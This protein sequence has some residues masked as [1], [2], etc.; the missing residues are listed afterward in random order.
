MTPSTDPQ[1]LL[2]ADW[3]GGQC[4]YS[5]I[6]QLARFLAGE[7][8]VQILRAPDTRLRRMIGKAYSLL[9]RWPDRNQSQTFCEVSALA[10]VRFNSLKTL[11]FLVGENHY[12]F[13]QLARTRRP[14][15]AT[16]H[17]P[18]SLLSPLSMTGCVDTLVLLSSRD[19]AGF[20]SAWGARQSV[21]IRHGVDTEFFSPSPAPLASPPSILIVGRYLRDFQ[22]T[23][24]TVLRLAA[25]HPEWIFNFVVPATAWNGPELAEVRTLA[26]ARWH[27]DVDDE[28]LRQL[29]RTSV[30]H[31]AV[32][33]DCT[34]NNAIVES[35]AC[36]LPI[37]TTD[38]GGVRDYGA[39]TVYPL[40]SAHSAEALANLCERYVAEPEWRAGVSQAVRQFAERELAW[41]VIAGLHLALYLSVAEHVERG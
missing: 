10:A 1:F 13:F 17:K 6:H 27:H 38:R 23:A 40:A 26:G 37:V 14:V 7:R 20:A 5:G 41:P 12:P 9:H 36:G 15:I 33:K 24:D 34:A 3:L 28:T 2:V 21:V 39:G 4:G 19:Q 29:Y 32:F 11:H 30:C 31:L 16:I 35:V 8:S 18:L 25:R 22:L